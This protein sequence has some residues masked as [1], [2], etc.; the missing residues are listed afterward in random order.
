MPPSGGELALAF[1]IGI[2]VCAAAVP[3]AIRLAWRTGIV[4]HPGGG[5]KRH[6]RSTPYLGGLAILI[7]VLVAMLVVGPRADQTL[8]IAGGAIAIC[9]IGTIDDW[10]PIPPAPRLLVQAGVG[11]ALWVADAGWHSELPGGVDLVLTVAW[12]VVATN[13]FNLIDNLDGTAT[14]AAA[15]SAIGVGAIALTSDGAAWSAVIAAAMLGA[16][17]GF[18][19]ANLASPSRIFLGDGGSTL[20]GFLIA[21]GTMGAFA[22][23]PSP[24]EC[25]VALL[26]IGVPLVDVAVA[27]VSR[28]R[29]GR[30]V[31]TGGRDHLTHRMHE[32]LG[33]ARTVA[34]GIGLAQLA[35]CGIAVA[36]ASLGTTAMLLATAAFGVAVATVVVLNTGPEPGKVRQTGRAVARSSVLTTE[37]SPEARMNCGTSF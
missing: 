23:E 13:A 14:A 17:L 24:A 31:L 34:A 25:A 37:F 22:R 7:G 10:R 3:L 11:V 5:Y 4:D 20:L 35:L 19:P 26:L 33:S 32:R 15:A 2:G 8:V 30:P 21:I 28:R 16:C 1:A 27:T 18:L 36:A 29:I 6:A 9:A 12:V